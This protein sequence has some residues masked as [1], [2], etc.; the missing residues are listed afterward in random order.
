MTEEIKAQP[1]ILIVDDELSARLIMRTHSKESGF[2]V[3]E[4]QSVTEAREQ[5]CI[6]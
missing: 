4:A 5:F 2:D 6:R 3:L 1:L